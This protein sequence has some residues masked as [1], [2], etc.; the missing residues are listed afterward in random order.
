MKMPGLQVHK[1]AEY[2]VVVLSDEA[3]AVNLKSNP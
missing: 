2:Q 3:S 1:A